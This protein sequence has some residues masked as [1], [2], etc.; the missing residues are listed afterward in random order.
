MNNDP[1]FDELLRFLAYERHLIEGQIAARFFVTPR[2]KGRAL[3]IDA[4]TR[5]VAP[6]GAPEARQRGGL[7][8]IAR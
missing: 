1:R 5:F 6:K 8:L 2:D 4:E 3:K 7:V